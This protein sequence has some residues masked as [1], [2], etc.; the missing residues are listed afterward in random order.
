MAGQLEIVVLHQATAVVELLTAAMAAKVAIASSVGRPQ[1][2]HAELR[3]Q[4]RSV[5][6]LPMEAAVPLPDIVAILQHSA[7]THVSLGLAM[8]YPHLDLVSFTSAQTSL[9]NPI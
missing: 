4:T 6:I 3:M 8:M 2:E 7:V 5:E 9:K 1:M